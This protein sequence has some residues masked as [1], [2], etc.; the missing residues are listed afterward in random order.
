MKR[1]LLSASIFGAISAT[2]VGPA[3]AD[4]AVRPDAEPAAIAE[5]SSGSSNLLGALLLALSS[6]SAQKCD[7]IMLDVC[8]PLPAQPASTQQAAL[9][10]EPSSGSSALIDGILL[11]IVEIASGSSECDVPPGYCLPR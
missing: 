6:G 9:I 10:G 1:I 7:G 11:D 3:T 4:V 2:A 8:V 5:A